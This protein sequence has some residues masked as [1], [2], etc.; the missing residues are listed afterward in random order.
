M[1]GFNI[2]GIIIQKQLLW[3]DGA[4]ATAV[5]LSRAGGWSAWCSL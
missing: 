5:L 2:K 4:I 3:R 1:R